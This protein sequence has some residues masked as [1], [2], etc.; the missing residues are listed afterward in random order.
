MSSN[1]T[2]QRNVAAR[3]PW[4]ACCV[5]D[6]GDGV[7]DWCAQMSE[8]MCDRYMYGDSADGITRTKWY[9]GK[10]CDEI[11]CLES[12][13]SGAC[14]FPD[15]I[16]PP[17]Q[18]PAWCGVV[19]PPVCSQHM[20]NYLGH[21][22]TCENPGP[23][24]PIDPP[25]P[26][27]ILGA[28]CYGER[29]GGYSRRCDDWSGIGDRYWPRQC[30]EGLQEWQCWQQHGQEARW[31]ANKECG[32][33]VSVDSPPY[34]ID[35]D[36]CCGPYECDH[37]TN[38]DHYI[39]RSGNDRKRN[40]RKRN[41]FAWEEYNHKDISGSK[42]LNYN[43]TQSDTPPA[44]RALEGC[45]DPSLPYPC[46]CN[47]QTE[48]SMAFGRAQVKCYGNYVVPGGGHGGIGGGGEGEDID[49]A[50]F[51]WQ[52]AKMRIP[53]SFPSHGGGNYDFMRNITDG[54]HFVVNIYRRSHAELSGPQEM[55]WDYIGYA[56]VFRGDEEEETYQSACTSGLLRVDCRN[57]T[58][59]P[60]TDLP[61]GQNG[62]FDVVIGPGF[63]ASDSGLGQAFN[64]IPLKRPH[65]ELIFEIDYEHHMWGHAMD[66]CGK[67]IR[68]HGQPCSNNNCTVMADGLWGDGT[69]HDLSHNEPF[70]VMELQSSRSDGHGG[71]RLRYGVPHTWGRSDTW[72]NEDTVK[73]KPSY[74]GL[75]G[76]NRS[77]ASCHCPP[78]HPAHC[79]D[80]VA[81]PH[82]PPPKFYSDQ[83]TQGG[84]HGSNG[85]PGMGGCPDCHHG[86]GRI[87]HYVNML[88]RFGPYG[89][90]TTDKKDFN[91]NGLWDCPFPND[92][93]ISCCDP[94]SFGN[95]C[96]YGGDPAVC[97]Q[98]ET[99]IQNIFNSQRLGK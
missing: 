46:T 41:Q 14:C 57:E 99:Q 54:P 50:A 85:P 55:E 56:F 62:W 32:Q 77:C 47:C 86:G 45:Y 3:R 6:D 66:C 36:T 98:H 12:Q 19:S 42:A 17:G 63:R 71:R 83:C 82:M 30:V 80:I 35:H 69:D 5:D 87:P 73:R 9:K 43:I 75:T 40:D 53:C 8:D 92:N 95:C 18:D 15:G 96:F 91:D 90:P 21:N 72:G 81:A 22:T 94:S 79:H 67:P 31:Y 1:R 28:C 61:T 39:P 16:G 52:W 25:P 70:N 51:I 34:G 59:D 78:G 65:D 60:I 23:C 84:G 2:N 4:G 11:P 49:S 93:T 88:Y 48:P 24:Y 33:Y 7:G 74:G 68:F 97:P 26:P 58:H 29:C 38:T 89:N 27:P 10:L 37:P 64:G 13:Q 44:A 76:R 20:G